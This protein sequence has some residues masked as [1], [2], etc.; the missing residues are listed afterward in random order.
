M[1]LR[2]YWMLLLDIEESPSVI[3]YLTSQRSGTDAAH[4]GDAFGSECHPRRLIALAA[5]RNGS[6]VRR[7]RLDKY[8]VIGDRADNVV[9][10]PVLERDDAA[11]R[12]VPAC[13]ECR[14]REICAAGKTVQDA[15]DAFPARLAYH[16]R[17]VVV[18]VARVHNDRTI[19]TLRQLEL[20]R[21]CPA[22]S[23][24]RRV[25]V[26][27]VE[28]ALADGDSTGIE[29]AL[30]RRDVSY[31]IERRRIVRMNSSRECDPARMRR[32]YPG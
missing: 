16:R 21:E 3:D 31:G 12:D 13:I 24:A 27:V 20:H 5:M 14:A 23:I 18:R 15:A 17:R 10:T 6:E 7:I 22:L 2:G 28:S 11:E 25:V 26:V 8:A 1:L 4:A 29:Q 9:A 32:R 30:E 19:E